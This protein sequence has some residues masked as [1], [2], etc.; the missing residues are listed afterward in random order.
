VEHASGRAGGGPEEYGA[1]VEP[2]LDLV[3]PGDSLAQGRL[4]SFHGAGFQ[5]APPWLAGDADGILLAGGRPSTAAWTGLRLWEADVFLV[6][7]A[8]PGARVGVGIRWQTSWAT[9]HHATGAPRLFCPTRSGR[10]VTADSASYDPLANSLRRFDRDGAERDAVPLP[11]ER[12]VPATF[13]RVFGLMYRQYR[14][15]APASQVPDSVQMRDF[16]EAQ[17]GELL[18]TSADVMPEYADLRCAGQRTVWLQ[19]FDAEA[20]GLGRGQEW[21][22]IEEDGSRT[23]YRLPQDFTAFR[24]MDDRVWGT[25][26]DSFGIPAVAWIPVSH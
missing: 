23:I 20:A 8:A 14:A 11:P 15:E 3:L 7:T 13:D 17:F 9:P 5:P 18:A 25:I 24:F 6:R 1:P 10:C 21:W 19:P 2:G 4:V 12:R 16:F 22:R 26:V